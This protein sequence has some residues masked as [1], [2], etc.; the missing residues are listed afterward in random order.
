MVSPTFSILTIMTVTCISTTLYSTTWFFLHPLL[1]TVSYILGMA[2]AIYLQKRIKNHQLHY[3]LQF[4]SLLTSFFGFYV[5]YTNKKL[6]GKN[7]FTSIHGKLGLLLNILFTLM[8]L[9]GFFCMKLKLNFGSPHKIAGRIIFSLGLL[10]IFLGI[11]SI[12]SKNYLL[13]LFFILMSISFII[14]ILKNESF[15]EKTTDEKI[16]EK[17]LKIEETFNFRIQK[18]KDKYVTLFKKTPPTPGKTNP[19]QNQIFQIFFSP[20]EL[21]QLFDICCKIC[22]NV[23]SLEKAH[24]NLNF[25]EHR[26]F[27][28]NKENTEIYSKYLQ[29]HRGMRSIVHILS[30]KN[31]TCEHFLST[32]DLKETN[33][34]SETCTLPAL[35]IEKYLEIYQEWKCNHMNDEFGT[36]IL[37]NVILKFTEFMKENEV[38]IDEI[39]QQEKFI[40][41]Q[42]LLGIKDLG[43]AAYTGTNTKAKA[44][45]YVY[46][47]VLEYQNNSCQIFLFDKLLIISEL[48]L[49]GRKNELIPGKKMKKSF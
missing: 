41:I 1:M 4:I 33:S 5:I 40:S 46:D 49:E 39:Y 9:N 26:L 13:L 11:Y 23:L 16:L 18:I 29:T 15:D 17:L 42:K 20:L 14:F 48:T 30:E 7:H 36:I 6:S 43:S 27:E 32:I 21:K 25:K 35:D 8:A 37:S 22:S 45:K 19:T 10:E 24:E 47:G 2:N 44:E 34:F 31:E 28:L 38:F 3:G 12:A